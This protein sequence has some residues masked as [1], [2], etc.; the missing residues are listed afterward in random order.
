MH[1]ICISYNQSTISI[2]TPI[3]MSSSPVVSPID[4]TNSVSPSA[5]PSA[6]P[7]VSPCASPCAPPSVSPVAVAKTSK[8]RIVGT[9]IIPF[10]VIIGAIWLWS[11]AFGLSFSTVMH[12]IATFVSNAFTCIG[13]LCILAI[14][15]IPIAYV[16]HPESVVHFKFGSLG[17]TISIRIANGLDMLDCLVYRAVRYTTKKQST[18]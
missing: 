13:L 11:I 9:E 4:S 17:P 14:I 2:N 7:S 3:I 15:V 18:Q 6:S 12:G 16:I 5:S 10:R 8:P 1:T